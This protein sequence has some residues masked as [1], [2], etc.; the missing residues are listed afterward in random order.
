MDVLL[1]PDEV[2]LRRFGYVRAAGGA[3]YIIA[4]GVLVAIYGLQVWPLLLGVPVLAVVTTWYFRKFGAVPRTVVAVS[5]LA[6][7]AVLGFAVA[8]V[9]GTGSGLVMV[10]AIVIVSGGILLGPA[11]GRAI[12]VLGLALGLGQLG[13]EQLGTPPALLHRPDL[14]ERVPVLLISLG[15]LAGVGYLTVTYSGRLH[16]LVALAG[17][18]AEA[19]RRRGRRRREFLRH[20]ARDAEASLAELER[21]AGALSDPS[22][23]VDASER[24]RLA[25]RLRV[26]VSQVAGHV[27]RLADVGAM[28]ESRDGRPEPVSLPTVVRDVV[29]A[30]GDRLE[31]HVVDLDLPEIKVVAHP[32]AARRVVHNLLENAAEHTPAGTTIRVT[33]RTRGSGAVLAVADDGPGVP[34]EL[35]AHLFD[36]PARGARPSVGLPLVAELC[37]GMGA[38]VR[39]EPGTAG[40]ARFFVVFRLAPAGAPAGGEA[41][42][43]GA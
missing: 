25:A 9:G 21:V 42:P 1:T 26:G 18:E 7:A 31:R 4:V 29:V 6:D 27:A 13:L 28:D 19:V 30:L 43:G 15:V 2:L 37:R 38:Q 8:F 36:P 3:A 12:T 35:H 11:A 20:A 14:G 34:A 10:Y 40:G 17:V 5:L 33:A 22:R 23:D 32:R 24:A 41:A 16:E 39:H